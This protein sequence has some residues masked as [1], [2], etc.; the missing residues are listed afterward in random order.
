[1][2][3]D[4]PAKT[5]D[6]WRGE[7]RKLVGAEPTPQRADLDSFTEIV[8][9]ISQVSVAACRGGSFCLRRRGE[10]GGGTAG[11][12]AITFERR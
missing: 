2:K 6:D 9:E 1:M 7:L 12:Q 4:E 11:E 10:S 3:E 8:S 5:S